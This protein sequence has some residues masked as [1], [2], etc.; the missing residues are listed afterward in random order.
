MKIRPS[1]RCAPLLLLLAP[2][3]LPAG[4]EAVPVA[5]LSALEAEARPA[6][7]ALADREPVTVLGLPCSVGTLAGRRAVVAVTGVGKVNA[8]MA[9]ALLLERSASGALRGGRPRL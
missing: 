8:A 3:R 6:V 2:A 9:T 1:A 7:A 5:I 4:Q